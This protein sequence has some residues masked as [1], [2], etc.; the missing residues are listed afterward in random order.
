MRNL[1]IIASFLL[2]LSCKSTYE[3][4][5]KS[6]DVEKKEE[7]AFKLYEKEDFFKAADLFKSLIQDVTG[8][9][10]IEKMFFF[11]AMCDYKMGDYGLAAYEFERLIQKFPRGKYTEESQFLIGMSNFEKAPP[12]Y[13]DQDYTKRAIESF[14]L[15]LDK[16]PN[17]KRKLEVNEKVDFL[18]QRIEVKMYDQAILY[19]R[20]GEYKS[21]VVALEG[22]LN[23]FPDSDYAEEVGFKI[24]DSHFELAKQSIESKQIERFKKAVKASTKFNKKYK[25]S[26]F[27]DRSSLIAKKSLGEVD[28]L[29]RELPEYYH[30]TGKYDK[31]IELYETLLRRTS[32]ETE[33]QKIAIKLFKVYHT[34]AQKGFTQNKVENY[35]NLMTYYNALSESNR[36][37]INSTISKELASS[38]MGYQQYKSSA[39]YQLY[40]E[41]KYFFA[42]A[43][44]KVLM[45]DTSINATP[46]D[47][48]FYMMANYRFASSQEAQIK[49]N[50]LD[51]IKEFHS[52]IAD[53]ISESTS[54]YKGKTVKLIKKVDAELTAYPILLVKEPYKNGKYKIGI[55]RAQKLLRSELSEKDEEEIVYLLISTSIKHATKGKKFE[56]FSRFEYAKSVCEQYKPKVKTLENIARLK[57]LEEKIN[58][59]LLRYQINE[60]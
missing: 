21:S 54:S 39:A 56:R 16:Y 9:T 1:V 26:K 55:T 42:V 6:R 49:Q 4:T 33:K 22:L 38:K 50:S 3:E 12:S 14:Q 5:L 59:A 53:K 52:I 2:M 45:K 13:L 48:Y 19:Y 25:E 27:L 28:R 17:S 15:F 35:E 60:E 58:K 30:K 20:M 44:Y 7:L 11:Y 23:E 34:K 24:A 32:K 46:K 51:S 40:K 8:G 29:K 37:S 36:S 43:Q 10:E 31:S 47:W 57:K 41:G 18:T